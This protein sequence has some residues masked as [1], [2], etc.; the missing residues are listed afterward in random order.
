MNKILRAVDETKTFKIFIANTSEMVEEMRKIHNT[1][2]TASA[3]LG[4]LT[5]LTSILAIDLKNEND[6]ITLKMKGNGPG[7]SLIA[8]GYGNG[9]VKSYVDNPEVELPLKESGKLDVGGY[10]GNEGQVAL[11][12]DYG[13]KEPYTGVS[14]IVSGEVAEDF[15][16]YFYTS[17]QTPTV[18]SLGVFVDYT[19]HVNYAGG[20][21]LQAMPDVGDGVLT[22]VEKIVDTLP[23]ITDILKKGFDNEE[24]LKE[25]FSDLNPEI[26]GE[27]EVRYECNCSREKIEEALISVKKDELNEM[28]EEDGKIEVVCHFCNKKY[29]FNK[30]DIDNLGA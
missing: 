26:V 30:E 15:A 10:V 5:T 4:R 19:S 25:Y 9:T 3:A 29:L 2:H 14:N 23:S 18:L 13:L 1:S 12:R 24:I 28:I 11:I 20:I 22:K 8:V 6:S 21:F 16:Y 17:E 27:N 7:G